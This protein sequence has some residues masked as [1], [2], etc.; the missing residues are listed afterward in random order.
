MDKTVYDVILAD[1]KGR[2]NAVKNALFAL[3]SY[4]K[5]PG[6]TPEQVVAAMKGYLTELASSYE[7]DYVH[8]ETIAKM[9]RKI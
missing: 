1:T 7:K 9:H 5:I 3:E 4:E 2:W 8:D 6:V